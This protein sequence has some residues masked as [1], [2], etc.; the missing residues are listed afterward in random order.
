MTNQELRKI[1]LKT[2]MAAESF[3]KK[4]ENNPE[5]NKAVL[6]QQKAI[7]DTD[8]YLKVLDY[9]ERY[10]IRADCI[11]L[12]V[13]ELKALYPEWELYVSPVIR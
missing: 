9:V 10:A 13:I 5:K 3:I 4:Y 7:T 12:E 6:R 2:K 8:R 11:P 1:L